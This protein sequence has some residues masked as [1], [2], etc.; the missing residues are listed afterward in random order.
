MTS[1]AGGRRRGGGGEERI[2]Q[3]GVSTESTAARPAAP[4]PR[5]TH[6]SQHPRS[7]AFHSFRQDH[8]PSVWDQRTPPL[9]T[10]AVARAALWLMCVR[11]RRQAG[12]SAPE[13]ER[14]AGAGEVGGLGDAPVFGPCLAGGLRQPP[15]PLV[16]RKVLALAEHRVSRRGLVC[17]D[18]ARRRRG[19]VVVCRWDALRVLEHRADL[20]ETG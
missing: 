8:H 15:R 16:Q 9:R 3:G 11:R 7:P 4:T 5:S 19:R 6:T 2:G 17:L 20:A 10:H 13:S 18:L 12:G 1:R 14:G